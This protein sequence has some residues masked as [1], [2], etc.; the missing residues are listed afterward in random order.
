VH[1]VRFAPGGGTYASGSEDGTIR[2][3]QTDFQQQQQNGGEAAAATAPAAANG[4]G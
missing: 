4:L 3:W 2:I 1:N